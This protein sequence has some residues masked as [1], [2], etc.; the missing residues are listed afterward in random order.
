MAKEKTVYQP[1][2]LQRQLE[3]VPADMSAWHKL[4]EFHY[5]REHPG[6]VDKIF[7][8]RRRDDIAR[9]LAEKFGENRP[10]GRAA[11]TVQLVGVI[12]YAMPIPNIALRNRVTN[13][14]YVG[15]G[16]KHLALAMINREIRSISRVVIHP[17]YR[18]IGLARRLVRQTLP[19]A[20]TIFVE[21]MAVMGRVNPFFEQAGMTRYDGPLSPKS[22]RLLEAFRH[23]GIDEAALYDPASLLKAIVGRDRVDQRF[24]AREIRSFCRSFH[25]IALRTA[26]ADFWQPGQKPE[27]LLPFVQAVVEHLLSNPVYYFWQK[28]INYHAD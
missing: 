24:L 26:A 19:R 1:C 21:A 28:G 20:G 27:V 22:I 8:L 4:K 12:I 11:D 5:R 15:L 23:T 10:V 17:Q 13:N 16:S 3:I 7:A 2:S 25:R 9:R 18:G 6:S 14:R